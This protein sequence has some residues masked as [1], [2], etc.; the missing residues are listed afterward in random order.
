MCCKNWFFELYLHQ[1][2]HKNKILQSVMTCPF[3]RYRFQM[4]AAF[5]LHSVSPPVVLSNIFSS[6]LCS[7]EKSWWLLE[8]SCSMSFCDTFSFVF[9]DLKHVVT[10]YFFILLRNRQHSYF[11]S[12]F[13][14][15]VV[16][17]FTHLFLVLVF[18]STS[19]LPCPCSSPNYSFQCTLALHMYF[20]PCCST[21]L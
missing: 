8:Y 15:P 20:L 5:L 3:I 2:C 16:L 19:S 13:L 18:L 10:W 4:P 6:Y 9:C 12:V 7:H 1:Y 14:L 21:G 17:I 11:F